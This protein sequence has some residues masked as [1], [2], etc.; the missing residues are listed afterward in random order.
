MTMGSV[1]CGREPLPDHPARV[2]RRRC[3]TLVCWMLVDD[4]TVDVLVKLRTVEE[5][6]NLGLL[7]RPVARVPGSKFKNVNATR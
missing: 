7:L 4:G 2:V 1:C 3:E 6:Q 5:I